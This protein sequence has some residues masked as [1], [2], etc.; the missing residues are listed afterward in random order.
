[1][2]TGVAEGFAV[3]LQTNPELDAADPVAAPAPPS[4]AAELVVVLSPSSVGLE[5]ADVLLP[6]A[7]FTETSGHLCQCRGG[8]CRA[9]PV[10]SGAG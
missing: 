4:R 5:Y 10:W 1:M 8:A 3:L 7:P 9:L 2:L 6:S